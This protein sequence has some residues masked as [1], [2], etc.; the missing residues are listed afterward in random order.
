MERKRW[1]DNAKGIGIILVVIGHA[2]GYVNGENIV[3]DALNNTIYTFHMPLFFFLSATLQRQSEIKN[4]S[5]Y[6]KHK[7]VHKSVSLGVP[8]VLFS[9]IYF[10]IKIVMQGS[11]NNQAKITDLL[12]IPIVPLSTLWYIYALLI[13]WLLRVVVVKLNIS[14]KYIL[15]GCILLH[16][17]SANITYPPIITESIIPRLLKNAV[18]YAIGIEMGE[19]SDKKISPIWAVAWVILLIADG[20]WDI[21]SWIRGVYTLVVGLCGVFTV[22]C[23]SKRKSISIF[24]KI[25]RNSFGIYLLHDYVVC[26]VAILAE[27]FSINGSLTILVASLC[28]VV[29]PY[30]VYIICMNNKVMK[31]VFYPNEL[32]KLNR[33]LEK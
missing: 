26:F 19:N 33:K 29:I 24:S 20:L 21:S 9:V 15:I 31:C 5:V 25:G 32:C 27:K 30:I 28:G 13:F 4:K 12:M 10:G 17:I 22:V 18:F 7:I 16:V 11:V 6:Q 3:W 23:I 14:H 8:Y 1:I 2:I